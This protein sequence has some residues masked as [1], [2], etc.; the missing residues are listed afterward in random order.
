[1]A[2]S[3]R[4]L[5][6]G[7]FVVL[8][9]LSSF[10]TAALRSAKTHRDSPRHVIISSKIV[11]E[12]STSSRVV[13][14]NL[15]TVEPVIDKL[16]PV[17]K[18]HFKV[19]SETVQAQPAISDKP[20]HQ[21]VESKPTTIADEPEPVVVS[22]STEGT[23]PIATKPPHPVVVSKPTTNADETPHP[24]V[25]SKST[26]NQT[27]VPSNNLVPPAAA[28]PPSPTPEPTN[29]IAQIPPER[30]CPAYA[31]KAQ[32]VAKPF[33]AHFV[34]GPPDSWEGLYV[35][36]RYRLGFCMIE[37][38]ACTAWGTLFNRLEAQNINV[39]P[40][41][42]GLPQKTFTPDKAR[43]VFSDPRARR[44][45]FVR[46]PLERVLSAFLDKCVDRCYDE[47]CP[48]K[49]GAGPMSFRQ[50]VAWLATQNVN[51]IDAHWAPQSEHCELKTRAAEYTDII[52]MRKSTF[53][54]EAACFLQRAGLEWLNVE[55][56]TSSEPFFLDPETK[57]HNGVAPPEQ[58]NTE[59][60]LQSYY[61]P[62]AAE[63]IMKLF[64]ADYTTLG[65]P[66][67]A[68]ITGAN[69]KFYDKSDCGKKKKH[70]L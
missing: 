44:A 17:V 64:Q 62:E 59:L 33:T 63:Q 4:L 38:N 9:S 30:H 13:E 7:F 47:A 50:A 53:A 28:S 29:T 39:R 51:L 6:V 42:Y 1:M 68:W 32:V 43:L 21:I 19:A 23:I 52:V 37:K 5:V 3:P 66:R 70:S 15:K 34:H 31:P 58:H 61:T 11:E 54:H 60:L 10:A 27:S 25:V 20:R 67:P 48:M 57:Q 69:G 46:D 45:V 18:R 26:P 22:K 65:L 40:L 2:A 35:S 14:E 8:G 16:P 55:S 41:P 36:P 56:G 24:V 49:E 12:A